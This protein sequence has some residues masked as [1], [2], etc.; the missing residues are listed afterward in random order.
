MATAARCSTGSS[1]KSWSGSPSTGRSRFP[2]WWAATTLSRFAGP[3]QEFLDHRNFH[4]G[5][6]LR[7]VNWRAY[8]RL[9][10]LFL[11]MFQVEPRV[12]VRLLLD[13]SASM[14]ARGGGEVRLRAQ[15]GRRALLRRPG[16]ARH[17]SRS[18]PSP[19]G[20]AQRFVCSGG[21]HRFA[22]VVDCLTRSTPA[23]R[24]DY[25]GVVREFI[26]HLPAARADHRHLR[27]PGRRRLR[28][29]AAVPG[30]LRPRAAAGPALGRGGPHAAMGGRTRTARR[31]DRRAPEA[32]ISTRGARER[33]TARL[34]RVLPPCC[35]T[36]RCAAAA[37]T[38]GVSTSQPLEEVIFGD[39]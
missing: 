32:A 7:A 35:S 29:A 6:D 23:G 17:A 8:L 1:W 9:E 19:T 31:R 36:W 15:A 3:G 28:T 18:T 33:Y 39:R 26:S 20:S 2:A 22:G 12:P 27:F 30:R 24:T 38:S 14:A 10:K 34:R 16:A 5:D 21:R 37:A 13:T 11:K 4:H 25:L